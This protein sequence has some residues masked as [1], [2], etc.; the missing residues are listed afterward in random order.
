[1]YGEA[2]RIGGGRDGRGGSGGSGGLHH[3]QQQQ[4]LEQHKYNQME[5]ELRTKITTALVK[6]IEDGLLHTSSSSTSATG[7]ATQHQRSP[8]YFS[9]KVCN[10]ITNNFTAF[11]SH[12]PL[13]FINIIQPVNFLS[14][15]LR[16]ICPC[17]AEI[18]CRIFQR[19][20]RHIAAC[21]RLNSSVFFFSPFFTVTHFVSLFIKKTEMSQ[22]YS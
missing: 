5:V 22:T 14:C 7:D 17:V 6:G 11:I 3:P 16:A 20:W 19:N 1:M 9:T 21:C 2:D 4:Q 10:S 8:C 15:M 12:Q 13:L 18:C